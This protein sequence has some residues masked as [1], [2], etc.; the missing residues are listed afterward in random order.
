MPGAASVISMGW[1]PAFLS[2]SRIDLTPESFLA[3]LGAVFLVL[4]L[5]PVTTAV[6]LGGGNSLSMLSWN[7]SRYFQVRAGLWISSS[8]RV[9]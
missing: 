1:V 2:A 5:G 4:A 6:F 7:A 8:I 9:A 3:A